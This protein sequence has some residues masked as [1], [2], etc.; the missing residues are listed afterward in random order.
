MS[1]EHVNKPGSVLSVRQLKIHLQQKNQSGKLLKEMDLELNAGEIVGLVGE[2]GCGKSITANALLGLLPGKQAHFTSE[3]WRLEDKLDLSRLNE[4]GWRSIR[5]RDIAMIFQDPFAA[6]DPVLR[7]GEQASRI[8]QRN[9]QISRKES[10][11]LMRKALIQCGMADGERVMDSYPHELSGGMRQRSLIALTLC[12]R[13]KVIIADEPTSALDVSTADQVL[14]LLHQAARQTGAAILLITHDLAAVERICDRVMVM[15][16]G[17]VVE[18]GPLPA[19]LENPRHPYTAALLNATPRLSG[20]P[21]RPVSPIPGQVTALLDL[22]ECCPFA[23][24]CE[25]ADEQ[26]FQQLP[27]WSTGTSHSGRTRC[28]HP[29]SGAGS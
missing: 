1:N 5:G 17:R 27:T 16:G 23:S 22:E 7:I 13:P 4:S 3:H 29:L 18:E 10:L 14:G 2:S 15:Y 25:R 21:A 9:R 20:K 11:Q 19:L 6:L 12:C 24:R 8:I 26:C 28:F